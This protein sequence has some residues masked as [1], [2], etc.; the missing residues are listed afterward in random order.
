[1][2]KA[3]LF[4][5]VLI[6]FTA[7]G[8]L[9]QI[10]HTNDLHSFFDGTRAGMGGYGKIKTVMDQLR[11]EARAKNIPSLTL[12]AGDFGEGSSFFLSDEGVDSLRALELL[13]IDAAVIGNHDFIL[14]GDELAR[15]L[16][17]AN[18]ST[19]ILSANLTGKKEM[20]LEGL[21]PN[22]KDFNIDNLK[23]R[24][25]GLTTSQIHFQYPLKPLGKILSEIDV[26]LE[27]EKKAWAEGSDFTIALTHIGHKTDFKLGRESKNIHLIVG[28]HSHTRFDKIQ[29][30]WNKKRQ[31]VPVVQTGAHGVAVGSLILDL[32]GK[33][34]YEIVSY[35]L[36]SITKEIPSHE[37]LNT[38]IEEAKVKR[39]QYFGRNWNEEIGMS[40]IPLSGYS[41]G[42][43]K[44]MKTCWSKHLA[45]MTKEAA[46]ADIGVQ[47]DNMQGE[48]ISPGTITFGDIIDNF[49]HFRKF[50]DG[51]WSISKSRINGFL[52][53]QVMQ[54]I[55]KTSLG[56]TVYGLTE[57]QKIVNNKT[58]VMAFPSEIAYGVEGLSTKLRDILLPGLIE[59]EVKYWSVIENY[60]RTHSPLVCLP[61][62]KQ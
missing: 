56:V 40:A 46:G 59:T 39:D 45:R 19:T 35:K 55:S 13:G 53:K 42:K 8:R 57:G 62:E 30:V 60:I 37:K 61:K 22:H 54:I 34:K 1:M 47:F 28:G 3:A 14:G 24:V 12:D 51:G 27:E 15:Q 41:N 52:V 44:S 2:L 49:P 6:S 20:G 43:I 17:R 25:L 33:G 7:H 38:F 11:Q 36:H 26:G 50:G 29:Y 9:V 48:E 4:A 58:Y 5:L 18:I 21:V 23:I 31:K 10:I 16:K 32:K